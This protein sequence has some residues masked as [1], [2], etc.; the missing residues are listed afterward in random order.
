M[1]ILS[2][3][4]R[5]NPETLA[6]EAVVLPLRYRIIISV[7][8]GVLII[9]A[10]VGLRYI[11]DQY[12][13]SPRLASYEK[14]NAELRSKYQS[15]SHELE[16]EE[17]Q[18]YAFQRKDDRMYRS[19]FGMDPLPSSIREAGTGGSELNLALDAI[20]DPEVV[21]DVAEKIDKIHTR[22]IIQSTSFEDLEEEAIKTQKLLAVK[23]L[24]PPISPADRYWFTSSYG[25][26]L[27]PFTKARKPHLGIDLAGKIGIKIHATG[28]G[29]VTT[30]GKNTGGYGN[31][32]IIDHGFGYKTRYAHLNEVLVKKGDVIKRGNIIGTMGSTGR[33]TGPHLHYEITLNNKTVNP[34]NYYFEELTPAQYDLIVKRAQSN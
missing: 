6:V 10:A 7:L 17:D 15:L 29:V 21:I 28:D 27:D 4:Y 20:S 23:P 1:K 33:S 32:V 34:I 25:Y 31:E 9:G 18:L 26:R 2:R 3:K 12:S 22:A 5:I 30:A 8:A 24:I 13:T 16:N 19:V 11:Y 14:K